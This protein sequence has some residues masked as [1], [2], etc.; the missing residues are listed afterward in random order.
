MKI[1]GS[2][3]CWLHLIEGIT[4]AKQTKLQWLKW[5]RLHYMRYL[6]Y[7]L[8][9]TKKSVNLTE[10]LVCLTPFQIGVTE[11]LGNLGFLVFLPVSLLFLV[12]KKVTFVECLFGLV[13]ILFAIQKPPNTHT[14]TTQKL[15]IQASQLFENM[16][17]VTLTT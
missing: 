7:G 16:N 15:G 3:N 6:N 13:Q 14:N 17:K 8:S 5:V 12:A 9:E 2:Q 10:V 4:K 11:Y 1:I